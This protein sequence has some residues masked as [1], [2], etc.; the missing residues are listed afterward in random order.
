MRLDALSTEA[1]NPR[2]ADLDGMPTADLLAV[3]NEE[4]AAVPA[5]VRAA[6]PRIALYSTGDDLGPMLQQVYKQNL[7]VDIELHSEEWSDFLDGLDRHRVGL[8]RR[9]SPYNNP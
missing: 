7:G 4:D 8:C 9:L 6:L 5:A 3:M 2:T 1:R